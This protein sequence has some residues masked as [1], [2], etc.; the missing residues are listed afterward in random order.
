[1]NKQNHH[2]VLWMLVITIAL[3]VLFLAD[4]ILGSVAVPAGEIIRMLLGKT[5]SKTSWELILFDIRLPKA[6]TALLAGAG[7]SVAGLQMQT[8]FR[9]PLAGPFVLGI[10]SGASLGVALAMM[11]GS[12]FSIR[13]F[14]E[15]GLTGSTTM[16]AAAIVGASFVM[17]LIILMA[18]RVRDPLTMLIVGL[19]FGS[20]TGALVSVLQYF[21]PPELIESYVIW[22]FGS[23]KSVSWGQLALFA[24]IVA[25]GLL[26]T[27]ILQ[28]SFNALLLGET[29]A[30]SL[31]VNVKNLRLLTI[32]ATGL[33]AGSVT[34][35]CGPVAFVGLAVPH[36]VRALLG[37]SNHRL[38]IPATMLMG[39]AVMLICDMLAELPGL[40]Q[41]LPINAVTALFGAPVV[42]WV[43]LKKKNLHHS[44]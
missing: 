5:A 21:S 41:T 24:P 15:G 11:A 42:I 3:A 33:L 16:A 7:L 23:L 12:F 31:G 32:T 13:W 35:F 29:Y 38:L 17:L 8:L 4:L 40:N 2:T 1:M 19:M 20:L 44:F 9:N 10:S 18:G 39:M 14:S 25:A 30:E 34:A 37:T 26:L 43:I 28:K 6:I 22:T 27:F 36:L